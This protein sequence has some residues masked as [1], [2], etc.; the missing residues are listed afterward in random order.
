M[1]VFA[2]IARSQDNGASV[3]QGTITADSPRQA[4]DQLRARGL[5]VREVLE[6]K[7]ERRGFWERYVVA[8]QVTH[9]TGLF[10]EL[11]TLLGAGI[12]LL[13]ALDTITRQHQ[14]RFRRSILLLRDHVAAGGTLAQA[15]ALEPGLFDD[16]SIN[17]VEVGESGG[18]LDTSMSRL[19]EFRR[20]SAGLR[21]RITAALIYPVIVFSMGVILSLFMMTYVMPRLFTV[22]EQSAKELPIATRIVK[23]MS[24]L[25]LNWWWALM[26]AVF[27]VAAG[28]GAML[29]SERGSMAWHRMQLKLPVLG[30]LIRKQSIARVSM[31]MSTL[32][33]SGVVFVRAM[34]IAQR[35]V[36][37]RVLRHALETC[38]QTV[39][40]G[41]DIAVALE[42]TQAFPPLV[43]QIFAVGQ[44]S[45][46][47]ESMLDS[48]AVDYETQVEIATSR[49][50]ALLEPI[51]MILLATCVGFIAF[52]TILPILEAGNVL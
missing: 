32:L 20:R 35:T 18:T 50:T 48:L 2:Y 16:L 22:L 29:R 19:V 15:M 21:N 8:R 1:A 14:G 34:Q 41:R 12:P 26:M 27:A 9:V 30:D 4:R 23:T 5:S 33:G 52:A 11:A 31:V 39:L 17:I 13:E 49:L 7:P 44:A 37:N 28:I 43:V 40:A 51:M 46:R 3:T 36:Q 47:L 25:L 45:G 42:R 10:Q 24:D 38:E 6:Q